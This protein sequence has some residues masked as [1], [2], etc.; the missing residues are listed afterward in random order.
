MA[1]DTPETLRGAIA[2]LDELKAPSPQ[3]KRDI[4]ALRAD[5]VQELAQLEA[6]TPNQGRL[7]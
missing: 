3:W 4:A 1:E 6:L 2:D 5:L 7:F